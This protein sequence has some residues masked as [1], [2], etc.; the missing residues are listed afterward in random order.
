MPKLPCE[1][2]QG[3]ENLSLFAGPS[4][5]WL[6]SKKDRKAAVLCLK[7]HVRIGHSRQ[8]AT[9]TEKSE[10]KKTTEGYVYLNTVAKG[11][12]VK[13]AIATLLSAMGTPPPAGCTWDSEPRRSSC[14]AAS[15]LG[16]GPEAVA[17]CSY[18]IHDFPIFR[19]LK[20]ATAG[21][22]TVCQAGPND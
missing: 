12:V 22:Q 20:E 7:R 9:L 14:L 19:K 18:M 16:V 6:P 10:N 3:M 1:D 13:K 17:L 21:F 11:V 2:E 4:Y 5:G 15:N 8:M